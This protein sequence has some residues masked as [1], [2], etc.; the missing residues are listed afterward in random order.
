MEQGCWSWVSNLNTVRH[1]LLTSGKAEDFLDIRKESTL[2]S[3]LSL[4]SSMT[5]ILKYSDLKDKKLNQIFLFHLHLVSLLTGTLSPL[6]NSLSFLKLLYFLSESFKTKVPH[7]SPDG[8]QCESG[9]YGK[10]LTQGPNPKVH[11]DLRQTLTVQQHCSRFSY[12]SVP[13]LKL[14]SL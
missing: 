4:R 5:T 7:W 12:F 8:L 3:W 9:T 1:N 6:T 2:V 11:P 13:I 14:P 10:P